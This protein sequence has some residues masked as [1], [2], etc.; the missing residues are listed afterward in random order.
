M[1]EAPTD[2][3]LSNLSVNENEFEVVVGTLSTID[4]DAG[5]T[6]TYKVSDDRFVIVGNQLPDRGFQ[7]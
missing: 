1:S 3:L 5:D 4:D 7:L 2:I 6:H